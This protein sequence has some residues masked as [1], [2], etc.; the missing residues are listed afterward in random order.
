MEFKNTM[1]T[2]IEGARIAV[3]EYK[4]GG[5]SMDAFNDHLSLVLSLIENGNLGGQQSYYGSPDHISALDAVDIAV[6]EVRRQIQKFNK[7]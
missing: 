4:M 3:V 2:T 6:A 1:R 7:I 5:M